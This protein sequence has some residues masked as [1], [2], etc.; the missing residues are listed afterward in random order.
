[1]RKG[2]RVCGG[3]GKV[4]LMKGRVGVGSGLGK[5]KGEGGSMGVYTRF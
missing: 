4:R 1:M 2:K 3:R 5:G